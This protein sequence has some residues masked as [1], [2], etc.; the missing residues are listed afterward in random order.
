MRIV[1]LQFGDYA[2]AYRRFQS[3]GHETYRD[4][5]LTVNYIA[6]LAPNHEVMTVAACGRVHEDEL[7]L[8]VWSI[9][10]QRDLIWDSSRLWPLLD[11]LT[12]DAFICRVPNWVA[13]AWAANNQVPTLPIFADTFTNKGLRHRLNNWRLSRVIRRCVKPCV[14]NHSLSASQSLSLVG[15]SLDEIV[16]WEFQRLKPIGEAKDAP[17]LDRPFRLFF[18]GALVESKGVGDC[19]QAVAIVNAQTKVELT[20]AGAG[21]HDKWMAFARRHGVEASVHLLGVITSERVLADMRD[22]DAVVVPSRHDYAEGLPNTI[23]EALASRSPLIASDH[24]AYVK[25]LRPSVDSLRFKAGDP[26][27][28]AKQVHQLIH[29]PGLYARLSHE[30]AS[31]LSR[32][33]VGI[34]WRELVARFIEDPRCHGDWARG[35]TLAALLGRRDE[36]NL[37]ADNGR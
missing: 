30:S 37:S 10:V 1:I 32:L 19:I 13:L 11:R 25:R 36:T 29:E 33:Y 3:G 35:Y 24:P 9:G 6:S 23:F 7:A 26:R 34:E 15:L 21:D 28:L 27:S 31:A 2:D 17:R 8:G 5:R 18:A 4:Q 20:L 16:P 14:G 22:S 12:P